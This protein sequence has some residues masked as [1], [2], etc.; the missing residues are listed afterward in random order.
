MTPDT[1]GPALAPGEVARLFGVD[2]KTVCRWAQKGKLRG[3]R[4]PGGHWR[5]QR[6]VI[7]AALAEGGEPGE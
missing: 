5:F 2:P 6:T 7:R 1:D 3:F 4:T